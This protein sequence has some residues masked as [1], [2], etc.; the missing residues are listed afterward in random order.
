MGD[1]R[2]LRRKYDPPRHPWEGERIKEE[3]KLER[4]FGLK[5][6]RE[7][8]RAKTITRKY[9]H[10]ARQLVGLPEKERDAKASKLLSKLVKIGIIKENAVLDDVFSIKV[11]DVLERRLQTQVWKKGFAK[12]IDQAR[13]FVSH[14][15]IIVDGQKLTSPVALLQSGLEEKMSW[16]RQ[17]IVTLESK[18][19]ES[20]RK[21]KEAKDKEQKDNGETDI[22]L[23]PVEEIETSELEDEEKISKGGRR[24]LD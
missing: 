16:S 17:P 6:K 9:R 19:Q 13:Q 5:N 11:S 12:S 7:I 3:H 14:G 24:K 2:K 4:E 22:E 10:L 15:H 21:F 8:W 18:K 1:P 23:V 20:E